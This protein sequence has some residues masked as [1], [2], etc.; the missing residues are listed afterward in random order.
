MLA[1]TRL[2]VCAMT[3]LQSRKGEIAP[4]LQ[5]SVGGGGEKSASAAGEVMMFER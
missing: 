1:E 5:A 3:G 4:P 2:A